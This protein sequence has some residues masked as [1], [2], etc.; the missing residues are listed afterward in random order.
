MCSCRRVALYIKMMMMMMMIYC[1]R[2]CEGGREGVV[3]TKMP[4][5]GTGQSDNIYNKPPNTNTKESPPPSAVADNPPLL[6]L[7]SPYNTIQ[8]S[9]LLPTHTHPRTVV[10]VKYSPLALEWYLFQLLLSRLEFLLYFLRGPNLLLLGS[11]FCYPVTSSFLLVPDI[12]IY[13]PLPFLSDF[14]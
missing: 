6:M 8:Y 14:C 13:N 1:K 4:W 10:V 5:A 3:T 2:I 9:L 7:Y 11:N 12:Q